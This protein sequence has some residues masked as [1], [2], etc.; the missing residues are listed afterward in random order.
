VFRR[1]LI[2]ALV[3][4]LLAVS[5]GRLEDRGSSR[6][7]PACPPGLGRGIWD[8]NFFG[9]EERQGPREVRKLLDNPNFGSS[10]EATG[11]LRAGVVDLRL[12]ATLRAVTR[13]H[14]ICVDAF[15]EGHYFIE[16][17]EDGPRIPEGYGKAG[18]L[19]NTHYHGRAADIRYVD[20]KPVEGN[21]EDSDILGVGR[22]LAG[23]PPAERPDQIIG[24]ESWTR[25]LDRSYEEGWILAQDQLDLHNDHIHLGYTR[26]R[27]TRNVR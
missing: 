18:G 2:L 17:V 21:G 9:G 10:G 25:R 22:I 1:I 4:A 19:P 16:G 23:L 6:L 14:S 5:C 24:P 26:D 20:G 27:G 11:D 3:A 7:D 15:K 12:V 13:K 8:G